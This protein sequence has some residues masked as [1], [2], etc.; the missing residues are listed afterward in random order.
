MSMSKELLVERQVKEWLARQRARKAAMQSAPVVTVPRVVTVTGETGAL[1]DSVA[2]DV[3]RRLG[4][5]LYDRQVIEMIGQRAHLDPSIVEAVED[6]ERSYVQA[7]FDDVVHAVTM[8][9]AAYGRRLVEVIGTL[10]SQGNAVILG[11]GANVILGASRALRIRCIAPADVRVARLAERNESTPAVARRHA[12]AED[13][14]R[15]RWIRKMVGGDIRD[16]TLYDMVVNT[17]DM[18]VAQVSAA[19]VAAYHA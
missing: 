13:E 6:T 19:I 18:T 14:R 15:T 7:L 5:K 3:A 4:Y 17:A 16:P 11:R 9:D 8:E 12:A 1:G 10:A 2:A